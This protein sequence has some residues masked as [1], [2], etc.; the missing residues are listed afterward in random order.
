M[1]QVANRI[2][3]V[4]TMSDAVVRYVYANVPGHDETK[5]LTAIAKR[6]DAMKKATCATLK[7][8]VKYPCDYPDEYE[9]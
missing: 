6:T 2:Y 1:Y 8:K 9:P 7:D 5:I 4:G 3:R